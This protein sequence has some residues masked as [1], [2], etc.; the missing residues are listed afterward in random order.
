MKT[1]ADSGS[2]ADLIGRMELLVRENNE[3]VR[4]IGR[5]DHVT[6]LPNRVQFLDDFARHSAA[7]ERPHLVLVALAEARHFNEI[8]RALGHSY[9]EDFVREGA[10]R[11]LGLLPAGS[12]VYHVSVLS[13]AFFAEGGTTAEPPPVVADI[14]TRFQE[15]IRCHGIPINSRIGVGVTPLDDTAAAA[16]EMLRSA[17]AAAQD[18]RRGFDGWA[19]YDRTSDDAHKR[20]FR[21]LAKLPEAL[22]AADRLALHF[23]PRIAMQRGNCIGAEAL[24]RWTD[25]ELGVVSPAEFVPLAETTALITPLTGWVIRHATRAVAGW[26]KTHPGLRI[27]INISPKNLEE[28]EFVDS[29]LWQT[30]AAGVDPALVELEFTE[31]TLASNPRLMLQQLGRL[32]SRGFDIAIDDFGSGYSN[33]SYLGQLPAQYLKIDQS[34]VRTLDSDGKNRVLVRSI[35]DLAHA[36]DY[37]VVAE[38]VETQSAYDT[39]AGWG[40]DEGQGYLMSRPL[41]EPAFLDWL[42]A[43][44]RRKI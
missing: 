9:S 15:P 37:R 4:R 29:M 23:Q 33:M 10:A 40:C 27:S 36:L 7:C 25:A 31:G 19:W 26:Q 2:T 41:P 30:E 24:I 18:S 11:L 1:S 21:I 16:N 22:A 43:G 17:L 28:P 13:F 12:P 5:V 32:R 35:I 8:L 3:A 44:W 39:L 34:F 6:L 20:S 38:G 42:H 14:V